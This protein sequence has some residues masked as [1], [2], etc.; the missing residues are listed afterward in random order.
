MEADISGHQRKVVRSAVRPVRRAHGAAGIPLRNGRT[1]PFVVRRGWNAPAGR[2]VEQFFLVHPETREV[3]YESPVRNVLVWGLQSVTDLT[4]EVS[5]PLVVAPG[6]YDVV[7][8]LGG[9]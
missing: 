6:S 1:L 2:Y 3:L 7:F 4:D 9:I 5:E 8:A